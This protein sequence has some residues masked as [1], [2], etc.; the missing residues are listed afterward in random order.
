MGLAL[1]L[2]D[3]AGNIKDSLSFDDET[4]IITINETTKYSYKLLRSMGFMFVPGD[5]IMVLNPSIVITD[6][7]V[8]M[9]EGH[10][11]GHSGVFQVIPMDTDHLYEIYVPKKF[12]KNYVDSLKD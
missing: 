11:L 7:M 5:S 6:A 12:Y 2:T 9:L 3:P 1:M 4:H 10:G 8:D